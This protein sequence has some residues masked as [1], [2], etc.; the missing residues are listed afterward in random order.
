VIHP[1]GKRQWEDV[2]WNSQGHRI[3]VNIELGTFCWLLYPKMVPMAD[4]R[5]AACSWTHWALKQYV[6]QSSYQD[7]VANMFCISLIDN[8]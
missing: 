7:A 4:Q 6:D 1:V 8:F 2:S 3:C 5:E